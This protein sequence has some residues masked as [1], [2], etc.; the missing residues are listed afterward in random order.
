MLNLLLAE[1]KKLK[2][3]FVIPALL[4]VSAAVFAILTALLGVNTP[5][6]ELLGTLLTENV[7]A[8]FQVIGFLLTALFACYLFYR[9]YSNQTLKT[10]LTI[11][12]SRNKMI[13]AKFILIFLVS[14]LISVFSWLGGFTVYLSITS[15][16]VGAVEIAFDY[17]WRFAVSG[18]TF[19]L[20]IAPFT[21][22]TSVC[23]NYILPAVTAVGIAFLIIIV[24][25]HAIASMF[26]P[27]SA[28]K[29]FV[30]KAPE[31]G[32]M[33]QIAFEKSNLPNWIGCITVTLTAIIG[34]AANYVWINIKD[35]A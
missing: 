20:T 32:G 27:W 1:I 16:M 21:L 10:V 19:F 24:G 4:L 17:L 9:E 3:T 33:S 13:T 2:R 5:K 34:F 25:D 30:F 35:A 8:Y 18:I 7:L 28:F 29:N 26:F 11:P 15:G 23:R 14:V 22:L 31:Y 12:V 6:K